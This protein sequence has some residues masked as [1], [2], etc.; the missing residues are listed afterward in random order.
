MRRLP[1][2]F[3]RQRLI[4]KEGKQPEPIEV[5]A[6]P[7]VILQAQ[8]YDSKGK[9]SR[10]H[11]F[12]VFGQL[13]GNSWFGQGKQDADGK[14]TALVPHGLEQTQLDL[15]TNEHGVLRGK[16]KNDPLHN[17]RRV[18]L[19]TLQADVKG[20]EIIRYTAPILLVKVVARDGGTLKG[21]A[22]TAVYVKGK[23]QFANGLILAGGRNSDVSFEKQEDGRFRSSQL[24]PD[25]EVAVTGHADGYESRAQTVK[26]AEGTT[27]EIVI[28]LNKKK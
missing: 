21:T 17:Q 28:E 11:A 26:L 5:R 24:F 16:S 3:L 6:V 15:M 23:G 4:L 2:V 12:F 22:A 18:D 19:G 1:G 27:K 20:I 8:H 10:G 25:Q 7:H 13:D 14:V 9:K